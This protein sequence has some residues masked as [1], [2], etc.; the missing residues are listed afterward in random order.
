MFK[1]SAYFKYFWIL[2]EGHEGE[3]SAVGPAV[4][5]DPVHVQVVRRRGE[6]I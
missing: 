3:V 1:G 6:P 4:N 2:Y 5:G